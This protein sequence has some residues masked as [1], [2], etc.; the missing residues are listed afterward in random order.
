MRR[1]RPLY[2]GGDFRRPHPPRGPFTAPPMSPTRPPLS[3]FPVLQCPQPRKANSFQSV[4]FHGMGPTF[5]LPSALPRAGAPSQYCFTLNLQQSPLPAAM[6][7]RHE[8]AITT[9]RHRL[10]PQFHRRLRRRAEAATRA[11]RFYVR[12]RAIGN[13]QIA[14]RSRWRP[15]A[16]RGTHQRRFLEPP[17]GRSHQRHPAHAGPCRHR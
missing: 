16:G 8:N 10:H 4:S 14:L 11:A 9:H 7:V 6:L 3:P 12:A 5:S 17:P 13:R 15:V 1:V 2:A